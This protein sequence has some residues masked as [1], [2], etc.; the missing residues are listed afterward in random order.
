MEDQ[1]TIDLGAIKEVIIKYKINLIAIIVG[2]TLL[3]MAVAFMLP[4]EY[5]STTL[6]RAKSQKQGSGISLQAASALAMLG[7][8]TT[9][10]TQAY[11]ELMK[12]RS[13]LD[14]IIAGLD[15]PDE[16]KEKMD[17]KGFA[18]SNLKIMNT[19]GTD[20]LEVTAVGRTPEEAQQISSDVVKSFQQ[21]LTKMNQSE[22]S[23]MVK[24]L[25]NRIALA[26]KDMEQAEQNLEK[27]RQQEKIYI[28]DEQAKAAIKKLTEID[29]K[30]AQFQVQNDSNQAKLQGVNEQLNKQNVAI[31]RYNIADNIGIQEIR[32]KIIEKQMALIEMQQRYTDKHPS[33]ILLQKEIGELNNKLSQEVDNSIQSGGNTLNPVHGGL[34]K[35]K[36]Q[37]E[38]ELLVGQATV[39]AAKRLQAENEKEISKLSASSITYIGLER[40]VKIA[41]EVYGVLVKNYEQTRI[42]EAMESMDIQIVDEAEFPKRPSAPRKMLITFIGGVLGIIM[43]SAYVVVAYTRGSRKTMLATHNKF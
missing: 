37:T 8:S 21:L 9:S 36:V 24:F 42:Q 40:Q 10:P 43:A 34:L 27:F 3:A 39:D 28:P 38:T 20:L 12:S 23:L 1:D 13:V 33:V 14:P 16:K 35:E 26:K 17:A 7:G 4:K 19:K 25:T 22:Q 30:I 5:E 18:K 41:Q 31:A 29:Q 6:L 32:T 11:M 2:C 15:L